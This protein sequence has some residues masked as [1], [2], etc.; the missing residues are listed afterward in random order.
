M[1]PRERILSTGSRERILSMGSYGAGKSYQ[2]L[3]LAQWLKPQGAK[4]YVI[5]T[6][7]TVERMVAEEFPDLDRGSNVILHHAYTWP[8]YMKAQAAILSAA[9]VGDWIV[10]DMADAPWKAVQSY[11]VSQVFDKDISDYFVEAR[12]DLASHGDK[13]KRG[14]DAKNLKV[15]DGWMDWPVINKIYDSLVMPLIF[16]SSAH[17]YFTAKITPL[18]DDESLAVR[19]LYGPYGVKPAGQKDLGH[20]FHTVLLFQQGQERGVW[21]ITTVKDRG[22]KYFDHEKLINF[23]IQYLVAKARWPVSQQV[24]L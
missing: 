5:D 7:D 8:A 20:L 11:F 10:F 9:G 4:F 19:E 24:G 14:K 18:R 22:R 21:Q 1:P 23:P 15:F 3:C 6:D 16:D 2:W 17:L 13:T 12:Q